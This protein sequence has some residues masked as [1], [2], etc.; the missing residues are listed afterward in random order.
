MEI[1]WGSE[2]AVKG[3]E[4]QGGMHRGPKRRIKGMEE[5]A[6]CSEGSGGDQRTHVAGDRGEL[7]PQGEEWA[8]KGGV[9]VRSEL[10]LRGKEGSSHAGG[11]VWVHMGR[12]WV[13]LNIHGWV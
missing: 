2:R 7:S 3:K 4:K 12:M 1:P 8:R 6:A 13:I 10:A 11:D 5:K 9:R